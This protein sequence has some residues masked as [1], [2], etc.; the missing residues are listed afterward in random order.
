MAKNA[1]KCEVFGHPKAGKVA[2]GVI[3]ELGGYFWRA[4]GGQKRPFK[5]PPAQTLHF[6]VFSAPGGLNHLF[7][8]VPKTRVFTWF[9]SPAAENMWFYLV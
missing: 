8:R 3:F 2:K 9:R 7:L 1:E 5:A 4:R 6:Y